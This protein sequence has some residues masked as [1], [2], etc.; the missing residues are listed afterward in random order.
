MRL[1]LSISATDA[2]ARLRAEVDEPGVLYQVA[3][4]MTRGRRFVGRVGP[5]AFDI[6]VRRTGGNSLAPRARGSFI[7]T[8]KGCVV[9]V[10]FGPT[11]VTRRR[12]IGL[13]L[14]AGIS[15]PLPLLSVGYPWPVAAAALL[16]CV[17]AAVI[18]SR[19]RTN[20]RGFPSS[21][22]AL[23]E[24]FIGATFSESRAQVRGSSVQS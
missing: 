24:D 21:E 23:L 12:L 7:P 10:Q 14:L 20:D 13:I 18:I 4:A 8:E 16:V 9:E 11:E 19:V 1:E 5:T 15:A 2:A 22:A 6:G 17:A 3:P